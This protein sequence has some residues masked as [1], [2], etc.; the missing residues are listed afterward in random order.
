MLTIKTTENLTGVTICG[1][2]SD[3][4][5]LYDALINVLGETGCYQN[6]E[7]CQIRVLGLCYDIRHAY[8]G[9]RNVGK[10]ILGDE[11]FSFEYLWP[12]MLF[13]LGALEDFIRLSDGSDCYL[14]QEGIDKLFFHP[15]TKDMLIDRMPDDIAYL[16]YF[17]NLIRNAL[18]RTIDPKRFKKIMTA[19]DDFSYT[20]MRRNFISYCPQWIDIQ[21]VKYIKRAPDK[22]KSYLATIA[23]KILFHNADYD[24]MNQDLKNYE[25]ELGAP[26]YEI[27]LE[28]MQYPEEIEW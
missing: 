4:N 5:T 8:Q 9:D 12:E 17:R 15:E 11:V 16:Q 25:K 10:D 23:E 13:I 2:Y 22:R 28:G 1:N 21:N 26:Y 7:Q 19:Y 6:Y 18:K 14:L 20:L 24:D 27:E 3:L